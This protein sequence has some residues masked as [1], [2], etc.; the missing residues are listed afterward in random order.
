MPATI[1]FTIRYIHITS[2]S[3]DNIFED[4]SFTSVEEMN[5][6]VSEQTSEWSIKEDEWMDNK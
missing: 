1:S 2:L 4:R 5:E 6:Q 3:N